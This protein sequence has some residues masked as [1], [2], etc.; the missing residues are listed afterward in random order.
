MR[1]ARQR[2]PIRIGPLLATALTA[3]LFPAVVTPAGP[4]S[5]TPAESGQADARLAKSGPAKPGKYAGTTLDEGKPVKAEYIRFRVKG[6]RVVG[7]QSRVW[8]H[9]WRYPMTYTQYPVVFSMPKAK[10]KKK[11]KRID[12]RWKQDFE[13]DGETE[14]LNGW[15]QLRFRG[16][17]KVTGR[18]SI[19]FANCATRLGDPPHWVDL[20]ARRK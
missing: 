11:K 17:G 18:L 3:M 16:K 4:A 5:A 12:H 8:V 20:R 1:N 10:I 14:T 15:V 19:D 2:R 13:V 7:F 9:C 6:K